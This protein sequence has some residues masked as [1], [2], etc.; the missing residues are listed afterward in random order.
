MMNGKPINQNNIDPN[1]KKHCNCEDKT[2]PKPFYPS[3]NN[4]SNKTK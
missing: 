2:G 3:N 1:K 4:Q